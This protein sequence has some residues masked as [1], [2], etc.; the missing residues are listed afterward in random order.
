M[1][2]QN[3]WN[4]VM[5]VAA[6]CRYLGLAQS[7]IGDM[8][9]AEFESDAQ[10]QAQFATAMAIAQVGEH[11]KGLSKAF[12]ESRPD[13]D[14]KAIAG[15]RDW[16]VHKY[17]DV[18]LRILYLSVTQQAQ[19]LL[20]SLTSYLDAHEEAFEVGTSGLEDLAQPPDAAS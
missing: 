11:V 3:P 6:I 17:D 8:S 19:P 1:A 9:F 18:D 15:T 13:V 16:L 12:R 14:W 2:A 20:D 4:D 7:F 5:H 10:I